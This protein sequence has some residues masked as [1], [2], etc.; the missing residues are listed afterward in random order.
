MGLLYTGN[1]L[2]GELLSFDARAKLATILGS[3]A[4]LFAI[5]AEADR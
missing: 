1:M 5:R 2:F 3:S 4:H